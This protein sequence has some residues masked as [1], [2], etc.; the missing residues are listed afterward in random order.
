MKGQK[1]SNIIFIILLC[2]I[3]FTSFLFRFKGI[4]N[5]DP[6]WVDEF[7]SAHQARL[8]LEHGTDVFKPNSI[9][10]IY[11]EDRNITTH[12]LIATSFRVFGENEWT[13]R[14]PIVLVGSFVP[15]ALMLLARR[16]FGLRVALLAGALATFSYFEITWSRQ[17]RVYII[18]QLLTILTIY[19]YLKL[20]EQKKIHKKNA[21][22]LAISIVLGILTHP[23]FLLLV[24]SLLAH[25][26]FTRN[27]KE[28][29]ILAKKPITYII[30]SL[31][32]FVVLKLGVLQSI[33]SSLGNVNNIWYYHSFL[34]REYGLL[35]FLATMGL[36]IALIQKYKPALLITL[37]ISANLVYLCFFL[38]PYTSR[39][40]NPIFP[41]ILLLFAYA[42]TYCLDAVKKP[43][44]L[45]N[46]ASY[47]FVIFVIVNG[48]KFDAKPNS[49][50]SVNHDFRE[51]AL[52][53]YHQIY[54]RMK[55]KGDFMSGQ[56]AI[57]ETWPDRT[58][59]YMGK[60]FSHVYLHQSKIGGIING[61]PTGISSFIFNKEGE[62]VSKAYPSMGYINELSDLKKT[63]QKYPKGFIFIDDATLPKDVL[64]YAEA[65]FKKELYLDHYPLDDNPYSIWPATLYSWGID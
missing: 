60:D 48:Y 49:F 16:V 12:F 56:T 45:Q 53:D 51:I 21:V 28:I 65:N 3:V 31:L 54:N 15:A 32:T 47:L 44:I 41:F 25:Y 23:L 19:I 35:T 14:L 22:W 9:L 4:M 33:F 64:E 43:K 6:F 39:Y 26:I 61:I 20:T 34:W 8:I 58:L 2:I 11:F 30:L 42:I 7:S 57:V 27:I 52:I 29:L 17:A 38:G 40:L 5:N 59:W 13:A 37:F 63:M 46:V 62:K 24:L 36:F 50:Y 18:Q 55:Q 10:P 1:N